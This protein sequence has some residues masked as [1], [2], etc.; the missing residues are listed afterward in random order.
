MPIERVRRGDETK[1]GIQGREK[2]EEK[3]IDSSETITKTE[4]K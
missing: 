1:A 4:E 3:K 2:G